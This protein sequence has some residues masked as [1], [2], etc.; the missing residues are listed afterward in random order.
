MK[1]LGP[2]V[3]REGKPCAMALSRW[4]TAKNLWHSRTPVI[5]FVN[6]A[7][8]G[9]DNFPGF[10]DRA[11]QN[12]AAFLKD[13]QRFAQT[14]AG[15]VLRELSRAEPELVSAFIRPNLGIISQEGLRYAVAMLPAKARAGIVKLH[16]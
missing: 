4:R 2:L 8:R 15:W 11:L 10:T 16:R 5:A 3:E 9:D 7:K 12:C 14:G 6:L 13:R 1:V